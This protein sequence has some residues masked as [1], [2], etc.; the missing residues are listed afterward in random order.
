MMTQAVL[1]ELVGYLGSFLV[2]VSMLMTS[3]VR[4][5]VI[6]LIGSFIFA[7]YAILIKSYPTA[8]LNACLVGINLYHLLKLKKADSRDYTIQQIRAGEGGTDW[9]IHRYH[10]D[11]GHFYPDI[12]QE[13]AER[14]D[15]FA[16][17]YEDQAAGILLGEKQE[18][19]FEI[20]LDYTTPV[21][22]DCSVGNHLY[23][24]LPD[25]GITRLSCT[26]VNPEHVQY[27]EKMGF[28]QQT[29]RTYT[30]VLR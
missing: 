16:I 27:M 7:T 30:K 2:L 9:F 11:I 8:F 29:D 6:N 13:R 3:V 17:F 25:F 12:D 26:S 21:Y 20:L 18:N 19:S 1:L 23:G 22:R 4:L 15:G 28:V 5:R 24:E 10:E 14:A